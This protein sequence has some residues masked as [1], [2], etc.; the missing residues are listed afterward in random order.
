MQEEKQPFL[1]QMY[2]ATKIYVVLNKNTHRKQHPRRSHS[3][4]NFLTPISQL[5]IIHKLEGIFSLTLRCDTNITQLS[6]THQQQQRK[7]SSHFANLTTVNINHRHK[8]I[9]ANHLILR[10]RI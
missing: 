8:H 7:I 3:H 4:Q 10:F 6:H 2:E 1:F 9:S 5:H